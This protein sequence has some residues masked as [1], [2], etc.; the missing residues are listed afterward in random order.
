VAG[1]FYVQDGWQQKYE[2][3]R[4]AFQAAFG[5]VF[6]NNGNSFESCF[7]FQQP[8]WPGQLTLRIKI[9]N[10]LLALL[11]SE[12]VKMS[13]GMNTNKIWYSTIQM[14]K[15]LR[16]FQDEGVLRIEI[17]YTASSYK[18]EEELRSPEFP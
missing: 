4:Q 6:S 8:A 5:R 1:T 7:Q 18:A 11:T 9:Y 17:S 2:D 13:L 16:E 15:I 10:K 3:L 14:Q 12:S